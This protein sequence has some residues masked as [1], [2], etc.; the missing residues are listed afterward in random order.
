MNRTKLLALAATAMVA[1]AALGPAGVAAAADS[2]EETDEE[3]LSIGVSQGADRVTVAVSNNTTG[4]AVANAS[5]N[6]SSDGTYSVN[7]T[8]DAAG[9]AA[10]DAPNE[11]VNAT[12][13]VAKNNST[14]TANV[15][16]NASEGDGPSFLPAGQQ[17]AAFVHSLGEDIDGPVGQLVSEFAQ[18]F[19]GPPEHAG[20]PADAG[21]DG[22]D[23]RGP[24]EDAG[25]QDDDERGPPEDA[26]PPDDVGPNDDDDEE[27]EEEGDEEEGDDGEEDDE[28]DDDEDDED[29]EDDDDDED[30]SGPPEHAG[31]S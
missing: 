20:P 4:A 25:P 21:P 6:V 10:F 12:I 3:S 15:T 26:G 24:P 7:G 1:L 17:I 18:S 27:D 14:G 16:L 11:T 9:I 5:V 22:D 13:H 29:D 2:G 28:E 30:D 31:N 19:G 8:T 23:E